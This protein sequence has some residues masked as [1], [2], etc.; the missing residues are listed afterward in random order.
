LYSS[1]GVHKVLLEKNGPWH[2]LL[3]AESVSGSNL[4]YVETIRKYL[5]FI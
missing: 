4:P 3:A 1:N 5:R 2:A